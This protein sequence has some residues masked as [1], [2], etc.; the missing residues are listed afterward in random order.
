MKLLYISYSCNPYSGSEDQIGWNIPI[1]SEQYNNTVYVITKEEHR[2]VIT[3]YIKE[4]PWITTKFF[5]VDIPVMY[6]KIFSGL[7]YSMRI[8]LWQKQAFKLAKELCDNN[9]IELIHQIAPVEI[10]ALGNYGKIRNIHFVAGPV[11][12]GFPIP[13]PLR[14]YAIN[15]FLTEL[16]RKII[17]TISFVLL[18]ISKKAERCDYI[19]FSNEE[20]KAMLDKFHIKIPNNKW[21]YHCD[22]GIDR[23]YLHKYESVGNKKNITFFVPGRLNYRKGHEL[24]IDS[25]PRNIDSSIDF[26]FRIAG[27]GPLEE[28]LKNIVD[29]DPFLKKHV[30]FLGKVPF[31]KMQKEYSQC[32]IVI[33]SSLSEATGTVLIEGIANSKPVITANYFGAKILVDNSC[34]WL[35]CG[36]NKNELI[37]NFSHSLSE[38]INNI[39]IIKE[40]SVAAYD[41]ANRY[42]WEAKVLH[43]IDIYKK[44]I[45]N[46]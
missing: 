36:K 11:S 38:A 28:Y 8:I 13:K 12:G 35:F 45:S 15:Y 32:D 4:H 7:F 3:S 29:N 37:E 46:S 21:E 23:N 2:E 39:D 42:T 14:S 22:V 19:F 5:F 1:T 20:T 18:K 34:A 17:N 9:N 16:L 6:K 24:L 43:F 31:T 40:K 27:I 33:L 44:C 26:S 30:F 25:I 41:F 10:R